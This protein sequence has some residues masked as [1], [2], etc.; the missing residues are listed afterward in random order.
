LL[1][2]GLHS[3]RYFQAALL[4]QHTGLAARLCGDLA[5]RFANARVELV[6]SPAVGGIVVGQEVGRALG[7]RAVFAEKDDAG[8][9]VF[10]RGFEVNPG[11]RVLI[12]EDVITRGG[13]VRQ[14]LELVREQGGVPVGVAV[15]VDRSGG[16]VALGVPVESLARL[17]LA[18]YVPEKCP[19]CRAGVP[20]EKP[21]SK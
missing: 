8:G 14:T 16:D 13:R 3:D 18:L 11:E 20:V 7:V 1:R 9:M 2:S 19:L 15:L 6:V 5:K 12:A 17:E 4:L 21:G 10:R